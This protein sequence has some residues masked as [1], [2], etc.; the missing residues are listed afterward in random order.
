MSYDKPM[1]KIGVDYFHY[2]PVV[3]DTLSAIIYGQ[4]LRMLGQT[5]VSYDAGSDISTFYADN[6]LYTSDTAIGDQELSLTFADVPPQHFAQMIGGDYAAALNLGANFVSQERGV[7]FRFKI[8]GGPYRYMRF[9]KGSFGLPG[10]D[11]STQEDSIEYQTSELSFKAVN[12]TAKG[13]FLQMVDDDDPNVLAMGITPEVL[14]ANMPDFNWDPFTG[15]S[16]FAQPI[17]LFVAPSIVTGDG[18]GAIPAPIHIGVSGSRFADSVAT[19]DVTFTTLPADLAVGTVERLSDSVLAVTFS[20]T[21]TAH[22]PSDAVSGITCKIAPTAIADATEDVESTP[23]TIT[24][25]E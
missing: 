5:E 20:G 6:G 10:A 1:P 11:A 22:T 8:S 18:T 14:E 12:T 13:Y 25:A 24:F 19:A 9:W 7:L 2:C 3:S 16:M 4:S 21:A 17:K 15:N 23:F